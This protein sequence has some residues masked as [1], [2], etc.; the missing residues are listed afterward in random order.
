[1]VSRMPP[2]T[3]EELRAMTPGPA[4]VAAAN[5]YIAQRE[6]AIEEARRIRNADIRALVAKKGPAVTAR[7]LDMKLSTIKAVKGQA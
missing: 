4:R 1:M 3:L 5:A 7:I 6:E 2:R